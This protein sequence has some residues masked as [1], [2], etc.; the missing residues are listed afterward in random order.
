MLNP[1]LVVQV[2]MQG[3]VLDALPVDQESYAFSVA[4]ISMVATD[5]SEVVKLIDPLKKHDSW[6]TKANHGAILKAI[7]N[8]Q[9]SRVCLSV[10]ISHTMIYVIAKKVPS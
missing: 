1:I 4:P 8:R 6:D 10:W 7:G 9:G 2:S 3:R 5:L